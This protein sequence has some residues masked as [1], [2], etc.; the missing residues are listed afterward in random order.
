MV[1]V[2]LAALA[3]VAG[4]VASIRADN[5][6]RDFA[7][8]AERA[9][10]QE[11]AR[12]SWTARKLIPNGALSALRRGGLRQHAAF[13]Q[14]FRELK[15][16]ERKVLHRIGIAAAFIAATVAGTRLLGWQW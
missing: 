16:R 9:F 6:R 14:R 1:L 12:Q 2:S 3:G 15:R 5:Y 10:P 13:E 7:R 11:W 8:W 4:F